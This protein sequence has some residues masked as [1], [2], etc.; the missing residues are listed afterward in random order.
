MN[1]QEFALI[2]LLVIEF[3]Q[4]LFLTVSFDEE[5]CSVDRFQ[6]YNK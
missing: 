3:G 6:I 4:Q 2:N 5:H 1:L